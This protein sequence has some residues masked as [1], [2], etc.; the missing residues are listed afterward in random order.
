MPE[1]PQIAPDYKQVKRKRL[2]TMNVRAAV[3]VIAPGLRQGA[4]SRQATAYSV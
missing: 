2:V 3:P 4:G 1:F